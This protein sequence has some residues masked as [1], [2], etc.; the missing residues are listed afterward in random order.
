M[1][2][3]LITIAKWGLVMW[4]LLATYVFFSSSDQQGSHC[5]MQIEGAGKIQRDLNNIFLACNGYWEDVGP[6]SHCT[7]DIVKNKY[8][9]Y[10]SEGVSECSLSYSQNFEVSG[11][12]NTFKASVWLT[13][14]L[15]REK[16][17]KGYEI[18][19]KGKISKMK[20]PHTQ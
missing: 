10:S 20:N 18:N 14:D 2:K 9:F 5:F 13:H 4:V 8:G 12:K 11:T 16:T 3:K 1:N 17:F 6:E 19:A 15:F 7:L